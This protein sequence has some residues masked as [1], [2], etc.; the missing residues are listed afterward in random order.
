MLTAIEIFQQISTT[1]MQISRIK[2]MGGRNPWISLYLNASMSCSLL[3]KHIFTW[4]CTLAKAI[5]S[6]TN[7]A[8]TTNRKSK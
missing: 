7:K 2:P 5:G 8:S 1:G 3:N 4:M 6:I